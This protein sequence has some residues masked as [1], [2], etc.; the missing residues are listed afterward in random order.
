MKSVTPKYW[1]SLKDF[2]IANRMMRLSRWCV[3][4][5]TSKLWLEK[6][7]V[8]FLFKKFGRSKSNVHHSIWLFWVEFGLVMKINRCFYFIFISTNERTLY[9]RWK[10]G[11][12]TK[13]HGDCE[14]EKELIANNILIQR[15][16]H[17]LYGKIILIIEHVILSESQSQLNSIHR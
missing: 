11:K 9:E 10:N 13:S 14:L 4:L 1:W 15:I 17:G 16:E 7:T 12:W 6:L 2:T 8:L 3:K 5:V